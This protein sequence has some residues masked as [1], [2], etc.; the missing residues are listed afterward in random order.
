[1][2]RGRLARVLKKA[3]LHNTTIL[4]IFGASCLAVKRD[5]KSAPDPMST[6]LKILYSPP[7]IR[8]V[9]YSC[10]PGTCVEEHP[11][12][13]KPAYSVDRLWAEL[14]VKTLQR[15]DC[16][17]YSSRIDGEARGLCRESGRKTL[18]D[19]HLSSDDGHERQRWN[20]VLFSQP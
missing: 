11:R 2:W 20:V 15:P 8:M 3:H 16:C 4:R 10:G 6:R 14:G 17:Q 19:L 18:Q 5:E 7:G 1:M 12:A 9:D 13:R